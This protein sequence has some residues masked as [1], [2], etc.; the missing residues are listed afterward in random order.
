MADRIHQ[1]RRRLRAMASSGSV[2]LVRSN[3]FSHER[4]GRYHHME[5]VAKAMAVTPNSRYEGEAIV[6]HKTVTG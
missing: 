5:F 2:G 1:M 6:R 4:V 3:R